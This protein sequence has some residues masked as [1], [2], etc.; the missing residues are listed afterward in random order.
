MK[1]SDIDFSSLGRMFDAMSDEE[2]EKINNM[3]EGVINNL[4]DTAA[5]QPEEEEEL[6][7][8]EK[9]KIDED[10]YS[11][12]P[13]ESLDQIEA[14]L[15]LEAYYEEYPEADLSA[16]ILFYQKALLNVLRK[17]MSPVFVQAKLGAVYEKPALLNLYAFIQPLASTE[18]QEKL[19]AC[20]YGPQKQIDWLSAY[21]MQVYTLLNQAEYACVKM[22]E[23]ERMKEILFDEQLL[24]TIF[25]FQKNAS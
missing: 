3:A 23:N 9:L 10:E 5:T 2:K 6:S 14:A 15:D 13:G 19:I 8:Y 18:N 16:S 22:A 24:K 21:L 1:L 7:I 25:D 20:G 17:Y 11:F 12:L 4:K